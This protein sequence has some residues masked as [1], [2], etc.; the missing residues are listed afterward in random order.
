MF[1]MELMIWASGIFDE[2]KKSA[3]NSNN[4]KNDDDTETITKTDSFNRSR[5]FSAIKCHFQISIEKLPTKMHSARRMTHTSFCL[6]SLGARP[7]C[8]EADLSNCGAMEHAS[9]WKKPAAASGDAATQCQGQL[10]NI[11]T[12]TECRKTGSAIHPSHAHRERL[13]SHV[14]SSISSSLVSRFLHFTLKWMCDDNFH[15]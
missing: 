15:N 3:G 7:M 1:R 11:D 5:Q 14:T 2:W 8:A 9:E 12:C 4:N 6:S 10:C 13:F